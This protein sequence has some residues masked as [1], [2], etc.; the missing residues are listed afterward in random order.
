[1][2][3]LI[4]KSRLDNF[5]KFYKH[6]R[7]EDVDNERLLS[8]PGHF[9]ELLE[10]TPL[11]LQKMYETCPKKHNNPKL[12]W[13]ECVTQYHAFLVE[14]GNAE[15]V[16]SQVDYHASRQGKQAQQVKD[17]HEWYEYLKEQ[18]PDEAKTID[19]KKS[20]KRKIA[21]ILANEKKSWAE[22]AFETESAEKKQRSDELEVFKDARLFD[23]KDPG[24]N[25]G[26]TSPVSKLAKITSEMNFET[27]E[28]RP[29]FD[30]DLIK[31]MKAHPLD[32]E[33]VNFD[34]S[35]RRK[36]TG[37]MVVE[38]ASS[39]AESLPINVD[40][41]SPSPPAVEWIIPEETQDQLPD[42]YSQARED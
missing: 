22:S 2:E 42:H 24:L 36:S 15:H 1:M 10:Q 8:D 19:E 12:D 39:C 9:K 28:K 26:E 41:D 29:S 38:A 33:R 37:S 11:K 20:N 7:L 35:L 34:A 30:Q 5:E 6:K 25:E 3:V 16:K 4:N 27:D 17:D 23:P 14:H 32:I 13:T 31:Q 40:E 18:N 21:E